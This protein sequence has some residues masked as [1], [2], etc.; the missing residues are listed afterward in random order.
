MSVWIALMAAT[1]AGSVSTG[2]EPAATATQTYTNTFIGISFSHPAT[3]KIEAKKNDVWITIPIREGGGVAA[4]NLVPASFNA[5]TEIWQKSQEHINNQ[6]GL[7]MVRQWQEEI[8][9][10]PLLMTKVR[11]SP[12]KL[13]SA[14]KAVPGLPS[15]QSL[16][17]LVGLVYS[18]TPRKL[19][20]RLSAT[21]GLFDDAEFALRQVLQSLRTADG[22]LPTPEDPKRTPEPAAPAGRRPEAPPKMTT[23]GPK[24]VNPASIPYKR[25]PKVH[26][27]LPARRKVGFYYPEGWS[28]EAAENGPLTFKHLAS[29][30]SLK[31]SIH[32]TLDSD[33][34]VRA[35][36]KAA[37]ESLKQFESVDGRDETAAA[38][39]QAGAYIARIWRTG[40]SKDGAIISFEAVGGTSDFYCLMT[41][42]G[43]GALD[44]ELKKRV[45]EMLEQISVEPME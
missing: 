24:T 27:A 11:S 19:L 35:L 18:A 3:W 4:L 15:D 23:I 37:A 32:S 12:G 2:Q 41:W 8:L 22:R 34:P 45:Q 14:I 6:M 9:G 31:L 43:T 40:K 20:F 13:A 10:V 36:I 39:N 1:A 29:G 44:P 42:Q 30:F 21:E 16:F 5:E 38:K 17:T 26:E 28:V 25:A 33:P 7:E